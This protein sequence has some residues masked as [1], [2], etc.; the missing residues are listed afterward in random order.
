M[1]YVKRVV[2]PERLHF[3][4]VKDGWEPLCKILN[5]P[6]PGLDFPK[7]NTGVA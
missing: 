7:S 6:T 1:E 2:P 3:V 5:K 4:H